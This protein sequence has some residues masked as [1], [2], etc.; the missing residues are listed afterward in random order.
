MV[1]N[2]FPIPDEVMR[3]SRKLVVLD[4]APLLA[5]AIRRNHHGESMCNLYM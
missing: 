4:I 2:T 3:R 1:T 5:E